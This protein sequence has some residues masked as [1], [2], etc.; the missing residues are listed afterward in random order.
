MFIIS[1]NYI[2]PNEAID[3]YLDAH[4]QFLKAE[5]QAGHFVASGRKVPRTGGVIIANVKDKNEVLE[6]IEKDPFKINNLAEYEI[7]EVNLTMT[8][9]ELEFMM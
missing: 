1:L 2:V 7:I 6:I 5:Y 8:C 9:R 3:E 4:V